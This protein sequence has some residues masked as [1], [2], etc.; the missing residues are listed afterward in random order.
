MGA[1]ETVSGLGVNYTRLTSFWK[2]KGEGEG[3]GAGMCMLYRVP[4]Y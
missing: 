4:I 2:R 1:N 3:D